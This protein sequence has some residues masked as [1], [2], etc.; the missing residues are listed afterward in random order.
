MAKRYDIESFA[1]DVEATLKSKLNTKI[2]SINTEKGDYDI[3]PI[4][5]KAY[6]FQTLNDKVNS[7]SPALFYYIDDIRSDGIG[8]ATSDD[9][10]IEIVIILSNSNDGKQAY[11]LLRYLRA[12]KEL[13]NDEFNNVKSNR[14]V[15]V[16]S[17]V[18]INFA[19]QNSSSYVDGIGIRLTTTIV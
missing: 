19:L 2:T 14:T 7:F 4:S 9:I 18:P 13:F 3:D 1:K 11:K 16:E 8:P 6:F 10:S 12:L 17:L 5:D 15:K